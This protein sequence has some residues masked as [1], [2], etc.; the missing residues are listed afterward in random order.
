MRAAGWLWVFTGGGS[1]M[2]RLP[3][4]IRH[5]CDASY[6]NLRTGE[7]ATFYCTPQAYFI[8]VTP[9]GIF[10]RCPGGK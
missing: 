6:E 9:S 7:V 3:G 4:R 8:Q 5:S 10:G 1:W 2:V